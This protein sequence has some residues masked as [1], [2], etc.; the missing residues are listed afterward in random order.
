MFITIF[1]FNCLFIIGLWRATRPGMVLDKIHSVE[2]PEWLRFPLYECPT[3]MASA[4][5]FIIYW[6]YVLMTGQ[7]LLFSIAF[8]PFYI[9]ALAGL[10]SIIANHYWKDE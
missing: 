10:N 9:V 7:D 3:C 5:S 8:Y 4:H 1:L 6:S 2:M